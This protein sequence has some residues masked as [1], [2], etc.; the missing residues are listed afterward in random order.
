MYW[1]GKRTRSKLAKAKDS[2]LQ[3]QYVAVALAAA[4]KGHFLTFSPL[5][6]ELS[7]LQ[8]EG[9]LCGKDLAV[10]KIPRYRNS[11]LLPGFFL[12]LSPH[13]QG[14]TQLGLNKIRVEKNLTSFFNFGAEYY[15]SWIP[16][17]STNWGSIN[18]GQLIG[19]N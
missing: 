10:D 1:M 6:I 15:T 7:G 17:G 14:L 2:E 8:N 13:S 12:P 16:S 11:L 4:I 18:W 9:W 19:V 5:N 3:W